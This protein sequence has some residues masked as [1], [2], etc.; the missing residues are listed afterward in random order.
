MFCL[1]GDLNTFVLKMAT[2]KQVVVAVHGD[3]IVAGT[4]YSVVLKRIGVTARK[5]GSARL[6]AI[7]KGSGAV[8]VSGAGKKMWRVGK[9]ELLQIRGRKAGYVFNVIR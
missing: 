7:E 9:V 5:L 8:L 6:N 1:V 3:E 4:A 2:E